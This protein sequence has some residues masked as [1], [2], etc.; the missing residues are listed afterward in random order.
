ME[1][2][3]ALSGLFV[4]A[5]LAGS[6][7]PFQ[8]EVV[9]VALQLAGLVPVWALVL[10]ASI[11]NTLGAMLNYAV[12]RG[13]VN[14]TR[15]PVSAASLARAERWYARWGVWSLTLSW[16][17]MGGLV[18]LVAGMMRTPMW[19]FLPLVAVPKT[20]RYMAVALAGGWTG[21]G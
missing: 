20:L 15:F 7:I 4:A 9:F 3:A 1:T 13:A 2:L 16:V 6:V 5:L 18:T 11:G 8:S 10:L 19:M 21:A 14:M 12:G 17:P